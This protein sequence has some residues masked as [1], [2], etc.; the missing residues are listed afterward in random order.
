MVFNLDGCNLNLDLR[1]YYEKLALPDYIA[2][3]IAVNFIHLSAI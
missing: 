1:N 3:L 2:M